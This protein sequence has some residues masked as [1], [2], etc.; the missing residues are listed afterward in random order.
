MSW[1]RKKNGAK[2]SCETVPITSILDAFVY[3]F[4]KVSRYFPYF[5]FYNICIFV[6]YPVNLFPQE[7]LCDMCLGK[8]ELQWISIWVGLPYGC[9]DSSVEVCA[10]C[11]VPMYS[12]CTYVWVWGLCI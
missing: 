9:H 5:C 10:V 11:S 6:D 7:N 3:H 12:I 8:L 4:M 1:L 2:K